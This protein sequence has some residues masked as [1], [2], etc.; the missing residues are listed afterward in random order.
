MQPPAKSN[1]NT[2]PARR[3][4]HYSVS[5]TAGGTGP[6]CRGLRVSSGVFRVGTSGWEF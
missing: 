3:N 2:L 1:F 5:E 4:L 6:F